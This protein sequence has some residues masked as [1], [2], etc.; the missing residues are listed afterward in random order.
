[1]LQ[2]VRFTGESPNTNFKQLRNCRVSLNSELELQNSIV[3]DFTLQFQDNSIVYDDD[4]E[5]SL[6]QRQIILHNLIPHNL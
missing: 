6:N 2:R 1:M 5:K 3:L 4:K